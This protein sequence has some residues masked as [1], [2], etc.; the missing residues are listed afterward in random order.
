MELSHALQHQPLFLFF[1][2]VPKGHEMQPIQG[3]IFNPYLNIRILSKIN[4]VLFVVL[5]QPTICFLGTTIKMPPTIILIRHAEALHS[6][7]PHS[8]IGD[9]C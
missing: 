3:H 7:C 4:F 9:A 1:F 5:Q 6:T 2:I 8:L